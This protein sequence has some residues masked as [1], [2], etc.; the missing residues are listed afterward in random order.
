MAEYNISVSQLTNCIRDL[1]AI[2]L[3]RRE[4]Q[5]WLSVET[6]ELCQIW[7]PLR[8]SPVS[9]SVYDTCKNVLNV[10]SAVFCKHP[11]TGHLYVDDV[12][13]L[14]HGLPYN[15]LELF[16]G[17]HQCTLSRFVLLSV[18]ESVLAESK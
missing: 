18:F 4:R 15:Q 2:E 17:W 16:H 1:Q 3:K 9:S 12:Q 10:F 6:L 8:F 11:S 7:C 13:A 5:K 14:V